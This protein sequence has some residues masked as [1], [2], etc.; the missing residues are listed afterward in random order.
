MFDS[1]ITTLSALIQL[2]VILN[3][4]LAV[5]IFI[6]LTCGYSKKEILKQANIA[7]II[8]LVL[9]FLFLFFNDAIFSL[10]KIDINSFRVGG[11]LILLIL[12]IKTVLENSSPESTESSSLGK[13][14]G[15]VVGTPVICGPGALTTVAS[16]SYDYGIPITSVVILIAL[17]LIWLLLAFSEQIQKA[18]GQT[19]ID[20][21]SKI[22]GLL[23]T[24][25]AASMILSGIQEIF[26]S[27]A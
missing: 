21:F 20:I 7:I 3:P 23:L 15:V 5:P 9:M 8:S 2:I 4:L 22:M 27:I 26:C 18:L 17:V 16:F 6:G 14:A 25:I 19:G 12:G 11:G 13:C 24:A 1:L 10:L